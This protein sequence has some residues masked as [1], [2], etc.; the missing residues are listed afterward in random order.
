MGE[1][2]ASYIRTVQ[3]LI[4]TCLLFSMNQEECAEALSSHANINPVITNTV[5]MELEKENKDF[6]E[7]HAKDRQDRI[8]AWKTES[9]DTIQRL[10]ADVA[11]SKYSDGEDDN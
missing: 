1:S 6:F 5:W 8:T 3:H 7:Q 2:S 4:E 9:A 11:A 10:V